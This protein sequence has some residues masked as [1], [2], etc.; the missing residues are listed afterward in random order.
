MPT[1]LKNHGH[2]FMIPS[3]SDEDFDDSVFIAGSTVSDKVPGNWQQVASV[4]I[5]AIL[6]HYPLWLRATL[7]KPTPDQA[8]V[9]AP[10]KARLFA[11][12]SRYLLP[13]I[14]VA[15]RFAGGLKSRR[16]LTSCP[17][18]NKSTSCWN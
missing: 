8:T 17:L 7:K 10:A 16:M 2:E 3:F 14:N 6:T 5:D 12:R 4:G 18:L 11:K 13:G 1:Y 15:K 9:P